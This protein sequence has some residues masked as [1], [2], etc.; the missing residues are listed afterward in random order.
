MRFERAIILGVFCK[1]LGID[2]DARI[3]IAPVKE[4]LR[5]WDL[6]S[7][8]QHVLGLS[9][10]TLETTDRHV[11]TNLRAL[12][13]EPDD[14]LQERASSRKLGKWSDERETILSELKYRGIYAGD[15]KQPRLSSNKWDIRREGFLKLIDLSHLWQRIGLR[16]IRR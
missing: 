5:I 12:M 9:G 4:G 16:K 7:E 13:R 11:P 8:T 1:Q 3:E 10:Q 6:N 14:S 2:S 15:Q